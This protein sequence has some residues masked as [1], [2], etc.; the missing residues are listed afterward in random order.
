MMASFALKYSKKFKR[1]QSESGG[2]KVGDRWKNTGKM[3]IIVEVKWWVHWGSLYYSLYFCMCFGIFQSEKGF[4]FVLW[5]WSAEVC[6]RRLTPHSP[7]NSRP[8]R[9]GLP[10]LNLVA[11]TSSHAFSCTA[12]VVLLTLAFG[13]SSQFW[14][15]WLPQEPPDLLHPETGP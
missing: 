6:S 2:W 13:S 8:G 5:F 3:L 9:L 11:C 7:R 4:S 1:W 10:E 12:P 14:S 15:Y